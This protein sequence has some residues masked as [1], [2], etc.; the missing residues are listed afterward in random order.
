MAETKS[1][2]SES[3]LCVT[4]LA[5]LCLIN[6]TI[7]PSLVEWSMEWIPEAQAGLSDTAK[8]VWH[9]YSDA[10]LTI[11]FATPAAL[12]MVMTDERHRALYYMIFI[13]FMV[14]TSTTLKT[15][16]H[17]PRP[18]M[19]STEI[20]AISCSNEFGGPS[21][22]S[23]SALAGVLV[24]WLDYNETFP[25]HSALVRY[26]IGYVGVVAAVMV[27]HSRMVLGV[28]SLD[29]LLFGFALGIWVALTMHYIAR[30]KIFE[31]AESLYKQLPIKPNHTLHFLGSFGVFALLYSISIVVYFISSDFE[32][33]STWSEN[34]LNKCGETALEGGF[35]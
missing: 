10:G 17:N 23:L 4:S 13:G 21:G 3:V 7:S 24:A 2:L 22:H 15:L 11:C 28:H 26:S 25:D 8:T 14:F 29:H 34:L 30:P 18:Y 16:F 33:P 32:I 31:A 19:V 6:L 20:E 12:T 1:V 35:F 9:I 5:A 27:G